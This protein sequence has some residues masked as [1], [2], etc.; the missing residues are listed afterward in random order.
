M[1][2]ILLPEKE[3]VRLFNPREDTWEDHFRLVGAEI[4]PLTGIG[5]VTVKVLDLNNQQ[6]I[7]EREA[8]LEAG[9][10]SGRERR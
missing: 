6:R 9:R 3:F 2:S 7:A 5:K 4:I 1:S 10:Y 8:L